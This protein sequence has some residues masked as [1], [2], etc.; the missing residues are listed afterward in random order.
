MSGDVIRYDLLAQDALRDVIRR[1]LKNAARDGLPGNHHFYVT[2]DTQAP[3]VRMSYR[4]LDGFPFEMTIILQHQFWDL[5]ADDT[6]FSV[7]LSFKG[8][9]EK[10]DVPYTAV[11]EF[12]DPS[13][14]FGLKFES[15]DEKDKKHL[16]QDNPPQEADIKQ[17]KGKTTAKPKLKEVK[18]DDDFEPPPPPPPPKK[19]V[20]PAAQPAGATV[21]S[22]DNFRKKK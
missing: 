17:F 16:M 18:A 1:V 21:V 6:Y 12:F 2:F 3:G 13:V 22:L 19:K 7:G 15:I 9:P 5:Q 11:K 10:L 4:L 14:N 8:M 20:E